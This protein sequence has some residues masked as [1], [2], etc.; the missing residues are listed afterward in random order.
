M[1]L[2]DTYNKSSEFAWNN[3]IASIK[4]LAGTSFT[5]VEGF[6][7]S[8]GNKEVFCIITDSTIHWFEQEGV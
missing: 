3:L 7:Y 1:K 5:L 4:I 2:V 6:W 8:D